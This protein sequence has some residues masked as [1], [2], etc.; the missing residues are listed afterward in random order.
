MTSTN[1][2]GYSVSGG[3]SRGPDAAPEGWAEAVTRCDAQSPLLVTFSGPTGTLR[4]DGT[5]D[6]STRTLLRTAL[7]RAAVST[8]DTLRI[9]VTGVAY[10]DLAGLRAIVLLAR[11]VAPA[12]RVMLT[13]LPQEADTMLHILGWDATPGL[14][15]VPAQPG[16]QPEVR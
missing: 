16:V 11:Q 8:R 5:I 14:A 12:R 1:E 10:C 6:E 2:P 9:D 13:G 7:A 3:G 4:L 15:V